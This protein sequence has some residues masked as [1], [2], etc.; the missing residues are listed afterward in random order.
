MI[1]ARSAARALGGEISG[2]A[3]LCPGPNH[4]PSDRSLSV[5]LDPTAPEGFVV[6]SHAGNDFAACRDHVRARLGLPSWSPGDAAPSVRPQLRPVAASER[7]IVLPVPDD[8]PVPPEVHPSLGRPS[9]RWSYF[10]GTGAVMGFV[11]RFGRRDGS[12]EFRPLTLWQ[13]GRDHRREWRWEAWPDPRP[14]YGL[15]RLTGEPGAPVVV[16]EG[17]KAADA[18][19]RLLPGFAVVTSP[20]GSKSAGK[21]DW[22]PLAGR[23]VVIWPDADA[24]GNAYAEEVA[25]LA[26]TAGALSIAVLM[27]PEGVAEG[28]DAADAEAEGWTAVQ[29]EAL[30][31]SARPAVVDAQEAAEGPLPLFPPLPAAEP[32]PVNALGPFLAEA[33]L[34]ISSKVQVPIEIAAQSVLA[35][36][37][38]AVQAHADVRLPY[39]QT[40]PTSLDFVTIAASGDRKSSADNEALWPIRQREK[41]LREEYEADLKEWRIDLAAWNASKKKIEADGK[42]DHDTRRMKL[43]ELGEEPAKPLA[44]IL[45][46]GDATMDGL[47]KNWSWMHGALGFFTAE[48]G[49][50]TAGHGM[51]DDNRLRTAAM[52]SELW[53]GKSIM[54]VRA[55]DGISILSGRRLSVHLMVQPDAAASFL[56]N[57]TLRDQGLLSRILVAAPASIAGTRFYRAPRHEDEQTIKRY[58]ARLLSILEKPPATLGDKPNELA[59]LVIA[60]SDAAATMWTEFFDH[61]E[62]QSGP[63]GDLA[64]IRDFAAKAAEHAARLAAVVAVVEKPTATEVGTEAMSCGIGLADWYLTESLRLARAS[65]TDARLLR[66]KGLLDWLHER[67][68]GE[69]EFREILRTGPNSVRTKA[70]AEEALSILNA[71][72]WVRETSTRPRRFAVSKVEG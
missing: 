69:I 33:A 1:D 70:A 53:D 60:I 59:P 43:A 38:L 52:L 37:A 34:A 16:C 50:F 51:S 19:A 64:P 68:A 8:A 25:R 28:W 58:G 4:R 44:P 7:S 13:S 15:D 66:A 12:K 6:H 41:T 63:V 27:L 20:N 36:S 21:A 49:Q 46:T 10:D 31:T 30:I 29:A 72:G 5:K 39:G 40:R 23:H 54:R 24:P 62:R 18:A 17:E 14:L 9:A 35:A 11:T 45:T 71:H 26:L 67:C 2:G 3:I 22:S 32:F 61:I 57:E 47:T 56:A 42:I 48:G 65:R 55:M